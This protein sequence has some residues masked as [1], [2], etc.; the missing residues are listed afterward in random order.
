MALNKVVRHCKKKKMGFFLIKLT[1]MLEYY[2][3][4]VDN[5]CIPLKPSVK[6]V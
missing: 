3:I 4:C 6:Y 1:K 2:W 5:Q